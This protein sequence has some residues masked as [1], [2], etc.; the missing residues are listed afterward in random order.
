MIDWEQQV[1]DI[2]FCQWNNSIQQPG[3]CVS[4][5]TRNRQ[6]CLG[7]KM[8][9]NHQ[10]LSLSNTQ[11]AQAWMGLFFYSHSGN[12]PIETHVYA[13]YVC[14]SKVTLVVVPLERAADWAKGKR[15]MRTYFPNPASWCLRHTCQG[16]PTSNVFCLD[17][18]TY[19]QLRVSWKPISRVVRFTPQCPICSSIFFHRKNWT[20]ARKEKSVNLLKKVSSHFQTEGNEI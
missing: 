19:W 14:I 12:I 7:Q 4:L 17:F 13:L 3:R 16:I 20:V 10:F 18:T 5:I 15:S 1:N 2:Q 11:E 8:S 6:N 9:L